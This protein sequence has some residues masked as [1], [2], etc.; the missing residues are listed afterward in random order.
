MTRVMYD[1]VSTGLIPADAKA[2]ALYIDGDFRN[3]GSRKFKANL[4]SIA[5]HADHD[6]ACLDIENGDATPDQAPAWVRRQLAR[7]QYRPVLY[8]ARD[9]MPAVLEAL[10]AAGI[11]RKSVRLWSAHIGIGP[12]I[13]SGV[14]CG[15][16]FTADG[17]QWTF[18]ARGLNLDESLLDDGF[19]PAKPK[20]KKITVPKVHPKVKGATAGAALTAGLTA[21]LRAVH[22]TI[23]AEEASAIATIGAALAGYVTPAGKKPA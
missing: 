3:W 1:S 6:A 7:G 22:V 23:T 16:G 10:R 20:R 13:C 11:N 5:V 4:L 2:V 14:S 12:H 21:I 18:T 9:N 17:T 15:A 8:S 19:F